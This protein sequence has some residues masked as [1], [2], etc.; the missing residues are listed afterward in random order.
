MNL[1]KKLYNTLFGP[2][3]GWYGKKENKIPSHT[4][5]SK[6]KPVPASVPASVPVP[7]P[8]QP[9]FQKVTPTGVQYPINTGYIPTGLQGSIGSTGVSM[10]LFFTGQM[11]FSGA[12]GL[13][14]GPS[15]SE[16]EWDNPVKL[17][18]NGLTR[19]LVKRLEHCAFG[20]AWFNATE[21]KWYIKGRRLSDDQVLEMKKILEDIKLAPLYL[22]HDIFKYAAKHV[23]KSA[24]E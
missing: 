17:V 21:E 24:G 1:F 22:N 9:T 20:P 2:D 18:L 10:W 3:E 6:P 12:T 11:G 14:G 16:E 15:I 23:L 4:I 19:Y 5:S 7:T 8:P 13:G